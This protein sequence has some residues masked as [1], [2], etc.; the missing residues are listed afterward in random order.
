[1]STADSAQSNKNVVLQFLDEYVNRRHFAVWDARVHPD[2][3]IHG[4]SANL[5]GSAAARHFFESILLTAFQPLTFT[6]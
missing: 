5:N 4:V 6:F 2:V 1:M 3:V